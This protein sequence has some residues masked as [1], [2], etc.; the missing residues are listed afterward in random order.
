MKIYFL[1]SV[2]G[3]LLLSCTNDD[4]SEQSSF[5]GKTFDHLYF[6]TEQECTNAQT[7]QDFFINCHQELSFT[8]NKKAVIMLTDI[9][10]SVNY[11]IE[12]NKIIINA[13]PSTSGFLNNMTFEIINASSL[14]LINDHT[15]WNERIG[16]TLWD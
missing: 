11:T 1:I 7:N 10:Y 12:G 3:I 15:T 4:D 9:R 2:I 16:N 14:K 8:D 5:I 6:K 13:S